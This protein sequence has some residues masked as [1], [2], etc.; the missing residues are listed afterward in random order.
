MGAHAGLHDPGVNFQT[1]ISGRGGIEAT[2]GGR[3]PDRPVDSIHVNFRIRFLSAKPIGQAASRL[4]E[5]KK[6]GSGGE[7]LAE[8]LK[9]FASGEFLEVII[10]AVGVDSIDPGN[11]VQAAKGLLHSTGTASLK[12]NT[13]LEIKGGKR[14]FL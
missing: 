14:V 4:I 10:V 7:E 3:P 2:R 9:T 11:N 8:M 12:N 5:I 6:K 1:G 13:Y